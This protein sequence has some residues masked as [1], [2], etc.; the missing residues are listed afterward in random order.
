MAVKVSETAAAAKPAKEKFTFYLPVYDKLVQK[1]LVDHDHKI[2]LDPNAEYDVALFAGGPDICPILYGEKLLDPTYL[3]INRDLAEI[4]FFKTLHPARLKV[5]ICRGAQLLNVMS[6]GT[7]WQDVNN[8]H[9][10]VG[11]HVTNSIGDDYIASSRHHQ[12]MIP[13]PDAW[14]IG[15]ANLSTMKRNHA[16]GV[17][18]YNESFISNSSIPHDPEVIYY[19]NT[20]SICF[21][22]HPEDDR[23]PE[24]TRAFFEY[25]GWMWSE[26]QHT[27]SLKDWRQ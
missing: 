18:Q 22:P 8:H 24:C 6:G 12:Q 13:G 14:V 16:L 15:W 21:Q 26:K 17:K 19:A 9:T 10:K 5:G 7:L 25:I 2:V 4:S 27:Q 20:N 23:F 1:M 11:H 3:N